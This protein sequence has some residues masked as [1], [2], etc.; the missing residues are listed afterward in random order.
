MANGT[1]IAKAYV[2]IIPSAEGIKGKLTEIMGGEADNA[3]KSAGGLFSKAF[4]G[5]L[6]P[7]SK[8]GAAVGKLSATVSKIGDALSP[9][10]KVGAAVSK[11]GAEIGKVGTAAVGLAATGVAALTKS[12]VEAYADY[13]Q[14]VGGVET[15]FGAGGQSLQE[16]AAAIGT[17]ASGAEDAYGKLMT[18]QN[19][20]LRNAGEAFKT[21]GLSANEYME[22]VTSFSAALISSVGGDTL[23]AAN[24]ADQAIRDMSDNANKMGTDMGAIQAAYQGFAKQN[25]TMLDNLKLGYGG[26]KTEMERLLSDA[27]A[28]SG[29]EYDISSLSDVYNAIHVI[30]DNLGI[31]GTTAKEASQTISGSVGAMKSAW[32]NLVAGFGDKNADLGKLFSDLVDSAGTALENILPVAEQ[33]LS[34]IADVIVKL[35]PVI[36]EKLPELID[37]ILPPLLSSA[38]TLIQAL[39]EALP[40]I[41][42]AI[43]DALPE[44]ITSLTTTFADNA[45]MLVEAGIMLLLSLI[46]GLIQAIPI[47]AAKVP[48]IVTKIWE[49]LKANGP[50]M[51]EA[52]KNLLNA[53]IDG[54]KTMFGPL[55]EKGRE[56][57]SKIGTAISTAAQKAIQWGRDIIDKIK[58]GV[59]NAISK[60]IDVG[61][62]IVHGIWDGINGAFGWIKDKI[63]GWVGN[64]MSFL[65]GLFGIH[66]PSTWARDTIGQNLALG[67]GIGFER[68]MADVERKMQAALPEISTDIPIM[69]TKGAARS[70][71]G[72][73][74]AYYYGGITIQVLGKEK[75]AAQFARELQTELER[76][77]AAWA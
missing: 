50:R 27:T 40:T 7:G 19:T 12:A 9:V 24:M 45:P 10:I 31:T 18:A 69:S 41:L 63:T 75:T 77:A 42:T 68:G 38:T 39:V 56:I 21:A 46:D 60:V 2:Q 61:K 37:Q 1:D 30:Q 32:E 59:S 23:A 55:M 28:L 3:G 76:R 25:Y 70:A 22:T 54:I 58:T 65:K 57:I 14:L 17:T 52:G 36:A 71:Y 48:E 51:L 11:I 47:L 8:I 4:G 72:A 35:A 62:N 20:V 16:Y 13:E 26:T 73:A 64:V 74:P 29:I 66:S 43:T 15:L 33:A 67:V 6:G 44:I 49:T 53:L 34:G 5:V